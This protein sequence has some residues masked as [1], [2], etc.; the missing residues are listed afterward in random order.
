MVTHTDLRIRKLLAKGLA[1]AGIAKKIG[2]PG[3][4]SRVHRI[5]CNC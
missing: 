4:L 1:C 3:D 5:G 2:R